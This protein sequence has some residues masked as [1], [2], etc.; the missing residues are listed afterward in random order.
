LLPLLVLIL[1]THP[2]I[3]ADPVRFDAA[4]DAGL[5]ESAAIVTHGASAGVGLDD[6][7][8]RLTTG[9]PSGSAVAAVCFPPGDHSTKPVEIVL[10][11]DKLSARIE[12]S[13][14]VL[15]TGL[16]AT[17]GG[18][19]NYFLGR[20]K[21]RGAA[22]EL[23]ELPSGQYALALRE[24][25][26]MEESPEWQGSNNLTGSA[27]FFELCTLTEC[28]KNLKVRFE[29]GTA[30]VTVEGSGIVAAGPATE[31]TPDGEGVR[32]ALNPRTVEVLKDDM[33]PVIGLSN[34]GTLEKAPVALLNGFSISE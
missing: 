18:G 14:P 20:G 32:R 19:I 33:E 4:T 27:A 16:I 31:R 23:R 10:D 30:S 11:V 29:D 26:E 2:G 13:Y 3:A 9:V 5:P 12:A 21:W 17:E 6:K 22:V 24:R 15:W 28:P 8:L 34:F 1:S 7:K 25:W